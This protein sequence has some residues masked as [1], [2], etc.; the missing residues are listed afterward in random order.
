MDSKEGTPKELV[1]GFAGTWQKDLLSG[2]LVF[3]IALPLCIATSLASGCPAASGIFT[4]V[5]G[6]VLCTFLSNFELTIKGP[7]AGLVVIAVGC[8]VELGG[9]GEVGSLKE[10]KD[11]GLWRHGYQLALGVGLAAACVQTL[12]GLFKFGKY[13]DVFPLAAVHGMLAPVGIIIAKQI[14]V[15]LT[16]PAGREQKSR[17]KPPPLSGRI[18]CGTRTRPRVSRPGRGPAFYP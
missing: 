8:V 6:G 4:A 10:L 14:P 17:P 18:D 12:F 15:A 16:P 11:L 3:L 5:I 9:G 13:G 1:G 2:F 7:A